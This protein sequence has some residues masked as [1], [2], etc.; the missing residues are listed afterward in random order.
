MSIKNDLSEGKRKLNH[1]LFL[2][3]L[4]Y[5]KIEV[6]QGGVQL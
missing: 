1:F 5:L 6:E 2:T 4:V 3:L